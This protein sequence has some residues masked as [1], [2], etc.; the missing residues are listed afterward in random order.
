M[1]RDILMIMSSVFGSAITLVAT[2]MTNKF[3]LKKEREKIK[4]QY[5]IEHLKIEEQKK[6]NVRKEK[7]LELQEISKI[8]SYFTNWLSLTNSVI[9][10]SMKMEIKDFDSQYLK[11]CD[12]IAELQAKSLIHLPDLYQDIIQLKNIHNTYWG[13]QRLLLGIDINQRYEAFADKQR[14]VIEV[15]DKAYS[16]TRDVIEKISSEV[17][18]ISKD[19]DQN[20]LFSKNK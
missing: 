9:Q 13:N 4:A 3:Q 7:I 10:T 11:N 8:T 14:I 1:E 15:S 6:E 2:Y 18:L 16:I 12:K 5:D 19:Y 20:T 17:N